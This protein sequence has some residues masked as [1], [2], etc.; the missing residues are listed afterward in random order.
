MN[1]W[2][3]Y[4]SDFD[5]IY[6]TKNNW[7]NTLINKLFRK[8]MKI[9]YQKTLNAIPDGKVS[10]LD[11]GCGPGHYCFSLAQN[12]NREISGIDY[13]ENMISLAKDHAKE[14]G[15]N[16]KIDFQVVDFNDFKPN[17]KFDYSIMMGFIEYFENPGHIIKKALDVTRQ[18]VFIS[19][20]K[21]GGLLAYQRKLRYKKRCYLKLFSRN[22]I[23]LLMQNLNINDYIIEKIG[24]DFFVTI[25][26]DHIL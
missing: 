6:G 19:F 24:R 4:A 9:R 8:S 11:I 21:A 17:Q 20:P 2:D 25:N 22:D 23:S 1:F 12:S 3:K 14:L 7:F 5:A 13:S 16:D 15:L 18:Q 10:V 26:P